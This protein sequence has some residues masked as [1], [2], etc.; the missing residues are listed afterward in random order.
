MTNQQPNKPLTQYCTTGQP[1]QLTA[2]Q[3][4]GGYAGFRAALEQSPGN[5]LEI[6]KDSRL[7]GRGGA[8]FPTGLKWSFV[9]HGDDAPSPKYLVANGD[10]MEPGAF[11]DR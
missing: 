6:I 1:L 4:Q 5:V 9:P 2:Y 10:E 3:E 8:G 7:R 11:K